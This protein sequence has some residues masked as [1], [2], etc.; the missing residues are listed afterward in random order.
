ME[1]LYPG[2]MRSSSR[3]PMGL[4]G[5]SLNSAAIVNLYVLTSLLGPREELGSVH[6]LRKFL[7]MARVPFEVVQEAQCLSQS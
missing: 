6:Q 7:T 1:S 5:V 2:R 4:L 3:G